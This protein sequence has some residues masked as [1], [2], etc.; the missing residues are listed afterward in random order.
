VN[1]T[2]SDT[3]VQGSKFKDNSTRVIFAPPHPIVVEITNTRDPAE[4][5]FAVNEKNHTGG[6]Y[7]KAVKIRM[8]AGKEILIDHIEERTILGK[9]ASLLLRFHY[10]PGNSLASIR[11]TMEED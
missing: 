7:A 10:H 1:N 3:S 11:E 9:L 2:T 4:T 6:C 5:V 8:S